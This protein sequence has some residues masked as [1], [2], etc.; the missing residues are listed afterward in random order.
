[1]K[2]V[3]R[4]TTET[5]TT[6]LP[7]L[8]LD[9]FDPKVMETIW[10]EWGTFELVG[11]TIDALRAEAVRTMAFI[12]KLFE[13]PI[14]DLEAVNHNGSF[15]GFQN[16]RAVTT[17]R[18]E[19]G[20]NIPIRNQIA[21]TLKPD[22]PDRQY[23]PT[24]KGLDN[25]QPL[26]DYYAFAK[27]TVLVPLYNKIAESFINPEYRSDLSQDF[28]STFAARKYFAP[29]PASANIDGKSSQ[30]EKVANAKKVGTGSHTD[31]GLL[32]LVTTDAPGLEALTTS[33]QWV[34][35]PHDSNNLRFI[36]NIGDWALFQ[37]HQSGHTDFKEGIHR[38]FASDKLS[39]IV[40]R[41]PSYKEKIQTPKGPVVDYETFLQ[42]AKVAYR[43]TSRDECAD[44]VAEAIAK[45]K[46]VNPIPVPASTPILYVTENG[47]SGQDPWI[48]INGKD[49]PLCSRETANVPEKAYENFSYAY[50]TP[51]D[52]STT[53]I[54]V[55]HTD[56]FARTCK[57]MLKCANDIYVVNES[58]ARG[59]E[60]GDASRAAIAKTLIPL[61]E[62][63]GDYEKPTYLINRPL[64]V[65]EARAVTLEKSNLVHEVNSK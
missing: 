1:M 13:L 52:R 65:D 23:Q 2:A 21:Y 33:G 26:Y 58:S 12:K 24:P 60:R 18:V 42:T 35:A 27:K 53:S 47:K 5:S 49:A 25:V 41:N 46:V 34:A 22:L 48:F 43:D 7:Q 9:N 44:I 40:E 28:G 15:H 3:Q 20:A 38:V 19:S 61:A 59:L 50:E 62:Y 17:A 39:L 4:T 56:K 14:E 45:L 64:L 8:N 37:A 29:Q 54:P 16:I 30:S 63:K 6:S 36:V 31:Y 11:P 57:V 51:S 32:T 55:A 10:K